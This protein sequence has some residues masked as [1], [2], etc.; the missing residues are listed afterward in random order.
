MMENHEVVAEGNG[1]AQEPHGL[2]PE[3]TEQR[4][5]IHIA[6]CVLN[7]VHHAGATTKIPADDEEEG[8]R[9]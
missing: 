6:S 3:F 1:D 8:R 2:P 4:H 7:G 9:R 5:N